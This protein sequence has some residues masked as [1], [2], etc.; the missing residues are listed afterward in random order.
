[1]F[2]L[3]KLL[4][5]EDKFFSLL[6]ASAEEARASVQTLVK[7]SKNL[8]SPGPAH[9]LAY[10]RRKDR[11]ITQEITEAVYTTFI[12]AI[13]R[14]D[15]QALADALYK[16]PKTV[17]K[18]TERALVAP[19]FVQGI[20]FSTQLGLLQ[21]ATDLLPKLLKSLRTGIDLPTVKDLTD[22]LQSIESSAD[23]HMLVLYKDL[24]NG[25][26][27]AVQ[28]LFLKDLY[29]L[30]ERAIDRCRTAGNVIS[31]IVLKNS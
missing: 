20:D 24:Y 16:I 26:Y 10:A 17:E 31:Q 22:K 30:L 23:K 7:L 11:Q 9:D 8:A 21:Q 2:S 25:K 4:G 1:M 28:V 3:Q 5:K 29:E 12:T 14:E 6:E 13:E 19:R 15:I 18:F 27:D